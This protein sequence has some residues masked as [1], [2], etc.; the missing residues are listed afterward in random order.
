MG[1][2]S[3][4]LARTAIR[5]CGRLPHDWNP[6]RYPRRVE[7]V[8]TYHCFSA[9]MHPLISTITNS[10]LRFIAGRDYGQGVDAHLVALRQVIFEQRGV[11]SDGQ[12]WYPYEVVELGSHALEPGHEREFALCTLL[13][14]EAALRGFDKNVDLAEKLARRAR[15][16][17]ALPPELRDVILQAYER[18]D[19]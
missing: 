10:E 17:D 19:A 1:K 8:E 7:P 18:A 9:A 12:Y 15:D 3:L 6:I 2:F 11:P 14:I 16:Y 13:V 4:R 5:L